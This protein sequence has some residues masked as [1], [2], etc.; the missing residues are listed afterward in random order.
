MEAALRRSAAP[1]GAPLSLDVVWKAAALVAGLAAVVTAIVVTRPEATRAVEVRP[2]AVWLSGESRGRVVLAGARSERP[3]L[4]VQLGADPAADDA[5]T[6]ASGGE[7]DLAEGGGGVFVLDRRS[8]SIEVLDGR[9][10]RQVGTLTGPVATDARPQVVGAGTTAYLIDPATSTVQRIDADATATDPVTVEQG[11]TDWAGA[12][13]GLLWLVNDADGSYMSFDGTSLNRTPSFAEPGADLQLAVVGVEPVVIDPSSARL[14][15]LRSNTSVDLGTSSAVLQDTDTAA[16]CATVLAG[17][18]VSCHTPEG[19]VRSVTLSAAPATD[20][21]QII[22]DTDDAVFTRAGSAG[23]QIVD[24]TDGSV[25]QVERRAPSSRRTVASTVTGTVLVDD[26]GSQFAF[27]VDRGTYVELDKFSKRTIIIGDDASGDQGIG[28]IDDDADVA[29]VFTDDSDQTVEPDD[30]GQNDAP[31]ANDDRAVTR[32]GRSITIDPLANDTDPEGDPLSISQLLDQI[33][34]GDGTVTVLNGSRVAYTPPAESTDRTISFRYEV[35]DPGGLT[36]DAT[37]SIEIIGSG[38]NTAPEMNDDEASTVIGQPADVGV[39]DNDIDAEGDPLTIVKVGE[40]EHGTTA[41]GADGT[42]RY[43]PEPKFV[44]RDTFTY[45]VSDGYGEGGTAAVVIDVVEASTIDRPPVARD[46]RAFTTAGQRVRIEALANDSDPDG[47]TISIQS[48][49]T[50]ENVEISQVGTRSVDVVPSVDVAGLI[51]FQYTIVDDSGLTDTARIS[52]WVEAVAETL[53]APIAVDDQA[54]TASVALPIDVVANDLD[55]NGGEL[56]IDGF[57]QPSDGGTVVQLGPT[58]LQF[59]PVKVLTGSTNV[60]FSY[61][62]RNAANLTA[63]ATVTVSV[64][65]PTGSGPVAKDDTKQAYPGDVVTVAPLA[66]DRHPD[67]L[68]IDF[69]APPTVRVGRVTVNPDRTLAFTPPNADPATY[70]IDYTIQDPNLRRSSATITITVVPRP[71]T[72]R[73]PIVTNDVVQTSFDTPISVDVLANDEDPDGDAMRLESFSQPSSGTTARQGNKVSYTPSPST[74]GV[75][76]FTYVAADEGGR[77]ATGSVTVL[78]AERPTVAPIAN[79]DFSSLIVGTTATIS[80]LAND[81]DPD[82]TG[83]GLTITGLSAPSGGGV[84]AT[85]SGNQVRLAG[86]SVGSYTMRYTITDPDGVTATGTISVAVQPVPNNPPIALNDTGSTMQVP[87]PIDVLANDSDP[88]GGSI[89]LVAVTPPS[90]GGAGSTAVSGGRV[91]YTP[92]SSFTGT[93]TFGYTVRD[94]GGATDTAT[95]TVTVSACPALPSMPAISTT[96]K[97]NTQVVVPLFTTVPAGNTISVGSPSSGT[98]SLQGGGTSALFTPATGFNG[99][100]SFTY[101]AR[102][103]CDRTVTGNVTVVVNRAPTASPDTLSTARNVAITTTSVLANDNDV[104][105]D[106]VVVDAVRNATNGTVALSGQ[107]IV[108]TPATGFTG[109]ATFEY[110][111]RDIGGLTSPYVSVRVNVAN[112][113]PTA[114]PDAVNVLTD[115]VATIDPSG[116]D[117]DPGDTLVVT[118]AALTTGSAGAG[119]VTLTGNVVSFT[120]A[121]GFAIP[122]GSSSRAVTITYTVADGTGPGALSDTGTI[123]VTVNNRLPTAGPDSASLDL[124][125]S[126]QTAP[127]N[128]LANDS[129]AETPTSGLVV[130]IISSSAGTATVSGGQVTYSHGASTVTGPVVVTYQVRDA[131]NGTATGTLTINVTDSTPPPTTTTTTTTPPAGP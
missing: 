93:A 55:P 14:R 75:V 118:S 122:D 45:E 13:D 103:T 5:A 6:D 131:N 20:G 44:G 111:V 26:P 116:N 25:Q 70:T 61:T 8:G 62:V 125:V 92:S 53:Q 91:I 86:V 39:L 120:Q 30:N 29:G 117:T 22:A 41:I 40:A 17:A 90:P 105:G 127:I 57:S 89:T 113:A 63:E 104:D 3:S 19:V 76:T 101:S 16:N 23:V 28:Q 46:D 4:A 35:A 33:P 124:F 11:F 73:P 97:F 112:V 32:V 12:A 71:D 106:V 24:W 80:P 109:V 107:S 21:L 48:V 56:T 69:A 85:L 95:V 108:F 58:A 130:S 94:S 128:V 2:A 67:G 42:V 129:D 10:G 96:T 37:I 110:R 100:A 72:N 99:Q 77:S 119:T 43:E 68:P 38:R 82:G 79:D 123:T 115:A 126:N 27:S 18:R 74:T 47:D 121:T 87:Y 66:N 114:N 59:T 54:T 81:V 9:D 60:S 102:N 51:T 65:P 78:V 64:T 83:G 31:D 7:Y 1:A 15:W 49:G 36:S 88:D 84:T 34:A 50:L 52:V 98:V